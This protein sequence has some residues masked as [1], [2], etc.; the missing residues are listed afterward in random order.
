MLYYV[1]KDKDKIVAEEVDLASP[2]FVERFGN[3]KYKP[4]KDKDKK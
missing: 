4:V 1:Y 3:P 2:L